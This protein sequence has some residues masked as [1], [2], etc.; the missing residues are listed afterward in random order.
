MVCPRVVDEK[1]D[2]TMNVASTFEKEVMAKE[3]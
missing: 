3:N 1:K 2:V